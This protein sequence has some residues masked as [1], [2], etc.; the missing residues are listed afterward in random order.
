M[1][2]IITLFFLV[3]A[4]CLN[5]QSISDYFQKIRNNEAE[6]DAFISQM[7]KG[8]DFRVNIDSSHYIDS[9]NYYNSKLDTIQRYKDTTALKSVLEILYSKIMKLPVRD[10]VNKFNDSLEALHFRLHIDDSDF[11]M[12]YQTF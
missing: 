1:K 10:S 8:V 11:T 12:R 7:T 9:N 5:A 6:L 3:N 4:Y 2:K